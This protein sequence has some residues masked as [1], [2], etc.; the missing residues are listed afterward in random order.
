MDFVI[1][2]EH[3]VKLTESKKR[4]KY[5]DLACELKKLWNIKV[6]VILIVIGSRTGRL[7]NKRTSGDHPNYS[8][9]EIGQ[10]TEKSLGDL[11]RFPI[12]QTPVRNHRLML[13]WKTGKW[14]DI[15]IISYNQL[16][17][18]EKNNSFRS[19]VYA[20]I[21]SAGL[22]IYRLYPL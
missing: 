6:K 1:S 2:A 16:N 22:R 5:Q 3:R 21:S 11:R 14:V 7:G 12:V 15:I 20:S 8:T 18:D 4:D 17:M 9:I 13:V 10:N 19:F